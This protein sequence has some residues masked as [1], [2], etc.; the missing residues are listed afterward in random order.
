MSENSFDNFVRQ[1]MD[2]HEYPVPAGTW[3]AIAQKKKRRRRFIIFWWTTGAGILLLTA[4]LFLFSMNRSEKP[5]AEINIISSAKPEK[6]GNQHNESSLAQNATQPGISIKENSKNTTNEQSSNRNNS[7]LPVVETNTNGQ[8]VDPST[9]NA[10]KP[11]GANDMYAKDKH[12]IKKKINTKQEKGKGKSS[13]RDNPVN[14]NAGNDLLPANFVNWNNKNI[15][16]GRNDSGPAFFISERGNT[17]AF[18]KVIPS[19][20]IFR[21]N[22]IRNFLQDDVS[23]LLPERDS[24]KKYM[25]ELASGNQSSKAA[26]NWKKPTWFVEVS[27]TALLPV[28][29]DDLLYLT[30][31]TTTANQH[32]S[33]TA[34][35]VQVVLQPGMAYTLALRKRVNNK[36]QLSLGLQYASLKEKI[37][38]TGREERVTY[39]EVQRLVNGS[40]GPEI[41]ADTIAT[42]SAGIRRIDALNS[43][44]LLSVPVSVQY[45]LYQ[46]SAWSLRL[47]GG[48]FFN[49]RAGYDNRIQ[50]TLL[51]T[52]TGGAHEPGSRSQTGFDLFAG[53]R[54]SRSLGSWE[55]FTESS[56]RYNLSR[57][58]LTGMLNRKYIHQPGV[59]V[60][61]SFLLQGK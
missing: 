19:K 16:T 30:R 27:A 39:E 4:G 61:A 25:E 45:Q 37:D 34:S 1:K 43:Y 8:Q 57:Y 10:G 29:K 59:T 13:K 44:Q 38:L 54:L 20:I 46:R 22:F 47:H 56:F 49:I 28:Q 33:Y 42:N 11:A 48:V 41:I 18:S 14:D 3:E 55:L 36:L 21:E 31:N 60:G 12:V 50:G 26:K 52:G 32:A 2:E 5:Q 23:L 17:T 58:N 24:V 15:P 40:N 9:T 7:D 6:T 51:A 53:V 35:D